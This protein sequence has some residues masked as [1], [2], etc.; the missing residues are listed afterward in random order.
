MKTRDIFAKVLAQAPVRGSKAGEVKV[1]DKLNKMN[2]DV[3]L[4]TSLKT[5]AWGLVFTASSAQAQT[6]SPS[7]PQNLGPTLIEKDWKLEK[8]KYADNEPT[9]CIASTESKAIPQE[10]KQNTVQARLEVLVPDQDLILPQVRL[11]LMGLEQDHQEVYLKMDRKTLRIMKKK[12]VQ[13]ESNSI[14]YSLSPLDLNTTIH[15]FR[16]QSSADIALT[17]TKESAILR[18]SLAGSS[19]ILQKAAECRTSKTILTEDFDK[20][21][22]I[23]FQKSIATEGS[24]DELNEAATRTLEALILESRYS[25]QL[26]NFKKEKDR[27]SPLET[28]RRR[29]MESTL[30]AL[31]RAQAKLARTEKEKSETSALLSSSQ[32]SLPGDQAQLPAAIEALRTAEEIFAPVKSEALRLESALSSAQQTESSLGQQVSMISSNLN[33]L[34]HQRVSLENEVQRISQDIFSM[35]R[36]ADDLRARIS[37]LEW[38]VRNFDMS[39]RINQILF[40]DGSYQNE[41]NEAQ[42]LRPRLQGL[43][44]EL[45]QTLGALQALTQVLKECQAAQPPRDCTSLENQVN[46]K[47]R[48]RDQLQRDVQDGQRRLEQLESVLNQKES[49]A[50]RQAQFEFNELRQRLDHMNRRFD[51]LQRMTQFAHQRRSQIQNSELPQVG[52]NIQMTESQLQTAQRELDAASR[53]VQRRQEALSQFKLSSN[54]DVLRRNVREAQK[55]LTALQE[56]I[57]AAEKLIKTLPAKL[58]SLD[59]QIKTETDQ[60]GKADAPYQKAKGEH[61]SILSELK[62]NEDLQ[63]QTQALIEKNKETLITLRPRIQGLSKFLFPV[64][65]ITN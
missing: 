51:E 56:K 58:A 50:Q 22:K 6:L 61:D 42:N 47:Q 41:K 18:L 32:T 20:W 52:H 65:S 28:Q 8:W 9:V 4:K 21:L 37:R 39:R 34:H 63:S 57:A 31:Q 38:E 60:V 13:A 5:I 16:A 62:K 46:E 25:S 35:E 19:K 27:L 33:S 2:S 55:S 1:V 49:S 59:A 11:R 53:Q 12:Q 3:F 29:V 26:E 40:N 10:N 24:L 44:S 43:N 30:S 17:S 54:F 45:Q 15:F 7:F 64:K 23:D 36:E 48:R 14:S